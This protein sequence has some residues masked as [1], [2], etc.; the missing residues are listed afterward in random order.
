VAKIEFE[1]WTR[2]GTLGKAALKAVTDRPSFRPADWIAPP[3]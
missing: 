1:G 2:D 3:E